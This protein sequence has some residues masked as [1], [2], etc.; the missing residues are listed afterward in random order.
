MASRITSASITS[1]GRRKDLRE[2]AMPDR[3]AEIVAFVTEA[4]D[5][6]DDAV[7]SELVRRW[8]HASGQE[9][10]DILMAVA[11]AAEVER[12]SGPLEAASGGG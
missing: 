12:R 6:D 7:L 9:V 3:F 2:I 1:N 4:A 5:W 8:P 10:E 11:V